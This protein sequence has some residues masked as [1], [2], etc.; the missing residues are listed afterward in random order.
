MIRLIC[1]IGFIIGILLP[2]LAFLK[3]RDKED[4]RAFKFSLFEKGFSGIFRNALRT[5]KKESSLF[6]LGKDVCNE[7]NLDDDPG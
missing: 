1:F 5:Q 3:V 4:V 2:G 6:V 7:I